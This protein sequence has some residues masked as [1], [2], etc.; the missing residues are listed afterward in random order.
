MIVTDLKHELD[1]A[2]A[3]YDVI[4]HRRTETAGDEARAIGVPPEAVAKTVVLT[5][6]TGYARAVLAAS[7]QL[8]LGKARQLLGGNKRT[9]LASEADL[10]LAYPM[11]ELG[12]VP[13]F[14]I[15]A[16]DRLLF[17]RQL[18]QRD[19]VIVEAGVHSESLRI[20][21]ADLLALNHAEIADLATDTPTA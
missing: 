6:D 17:D 12:A 9:R 8:D 21:T 1:L 14:G 11:Y 16:G 4:D 5:T 13:P 10:V 19:T 7:D 15:P 20:K 2:G 3:E 18:A